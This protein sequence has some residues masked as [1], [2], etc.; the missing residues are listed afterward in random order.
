MRPIAEVLVFTASGLG[1]LFLPGYAVGWPQLALAVLYWLAT[2]SA[3]RTQPRSVARIYRRNTLILFAACFAALLGLTTATG[4]LLL[5]VGSVV[6][7]RLRNHG[8]PNPDRNDV[9]VLLKSF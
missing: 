7:V 6:A 1:V 9:P 8:H 4:L 2:R 5:V 3:V